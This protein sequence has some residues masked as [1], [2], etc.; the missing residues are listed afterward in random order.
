MLSS[1]TGRFKTSYAAD[2]AIQRVPLARIAFW[3]AIL[4]TFLVVPRVFDNVWLN[5]FNL[6]LIAVVAVTGLNLLV[7][8]T[9]Q[10]SLGHAAFAMMGAFTV[11]L[12]YNR[13][14]ELRAN[15]YNLLLTIPLAGLVATVVGTLFGVPS[16]RVK[17]LYLSIATL[18]AHPILTWVVEHLAPKLTVT[19]R[20][21]SSLPTRRPTI[22][23]FGWE[24]QIRTDAD[25]FYLFA[26]LAILGIVIA[27]N[28][29]RTRLVRAL[30]A[31]RDNDIAAES[32]GISLY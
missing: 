26:F 28:L 5:N 8:Y 10:I 1:E 12:L 30:I 24:H 7:G 15:P 32:V 6:V 27:Q 22:G 9:G 2:M 16:L 23:L 14:P 19:G 18:A 21:F 29:V 20:S 31:I 17:G 11:A 4:V 25:K 3:G 13:W